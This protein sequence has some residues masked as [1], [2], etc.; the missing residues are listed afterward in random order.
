[1]LG[2]QINTI[3]TQ[4]EGERPVLSESLLPTHCVLYKHNL[5][6]HIFYHILPTHTPS[7]EIWNHIR[8]IIIHIK[9]GETWCVLRL[10]VIINSVRGNQIKFN[11]HEHVPLRMI[12]VYSRLVQT[13]RIIR[14]HWARVCLHKQT[15]LCDVITS[16]PRR[17]E[18]WAKQC[19][20]TQ[21]IRL[22]T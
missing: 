17:V 7:E 3:I 21:L 12:A 14:R 15:E 9:P 2:E 1:M 5:L 13:T 10:L 16:S 20:Q 19:T 6:T 22:S 4:W 11:V 18:R 8:I